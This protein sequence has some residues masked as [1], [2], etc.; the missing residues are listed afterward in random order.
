MGLGDI[1]K[2]GILHRRHIT[3]NVYTVIFDLQS[4]LKFRF[5][6]IVIYV[7]LG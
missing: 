2:L 5:Y 1:T 4:R 3:K 7:I 6:Y